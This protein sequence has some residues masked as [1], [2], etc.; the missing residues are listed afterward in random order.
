L[1][2]C[3]VQIVH[4]FLLFVKLKFT[5]HKNPLFFDVFVWPIHARKLLACASFY[6][7]RDFIG[8]FAFFYKLGGI[9]NG[10]QICPRTRFLRLTHPGIP[11][12]GISFNLAAIPFASQKYWIGYTGQKKGPA[13][14][15]DWR[16]AGEGDPLG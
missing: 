2:P 16:G 1:H 4:S 7:Y 14:E 13:R 6:E 5:I 12:G 8:V 11:P 15:W 3:Y 9:I 10:F